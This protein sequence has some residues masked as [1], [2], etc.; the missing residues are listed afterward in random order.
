MVAACHVSAQDSQYCSGTH[1]F[2][3]LD[4]WLSWLNATTEAL[5]HLTSMLTVTLDLRQIWARDK[6]LIGSG[7]VEVLLLGKLFQ[8]REGSKG[9]L[10]GTVTDLRKES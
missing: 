2:F 5:V 8:T 10:K 4:A 6:H 1:G 9:G 7:M 3:G